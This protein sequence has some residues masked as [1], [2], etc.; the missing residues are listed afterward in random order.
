MPF[1][2]LAPVAIAIGTSAVPVGL[3]HEVN[4]THIS[5]R[6]LQVDGSL[7]DRTIVAEHGRAIRLDDW[8]IAQDA[9]T[10]LRRGEPQEF[11]STELDGETLTLVVY[12]VITVPAGTTGGRGTIVNGRTYINDFIN[13][14]ET[15][16]GLTLSVDLGD[17]Q[18]PEDVAAELYL[19][20][21][22]G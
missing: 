16:V 8:P 11:T 6:P 18:K 13:G 3:V 5:I 7:S 15:I 17:L 2:E 22:W 19:K 21:S 14:V 20:T 10:Y 12:N 9:D 4:E 1:E